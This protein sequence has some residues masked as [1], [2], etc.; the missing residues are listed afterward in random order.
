MNVG[1]FIKIY[2]VYIIDV[3][4]NLYQLELSVNYS[5]F[6]QHNLYYV[7]VYS[8]ASKGIGPDQDPPHHHNF[9]NFM[10]GIYF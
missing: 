4:C 1:I 6:D 8:D 7:L 2:Q 10:F 3:R 5:C 9:A